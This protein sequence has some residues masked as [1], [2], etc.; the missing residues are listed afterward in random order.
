MEP[1]ITPN[2]QTQPTEAPKASKFTII[3]IV[4]ILISAGFL[5]Y[6]VYKSN[7]E[8]NTTT[9]TTDSAT[10]AEPVPTTN[11]P[12]TTPSTD[13]SAPITPPATVPPASTPSTNA[14]PSGASFTAAQ[15][16]EKNSKSSCWTIIS[17]NVYD[18]TSYVPNHPGGEAEIVK[19]CGKDGTALF[20]KPMEHKEGGASNVLAGF[21]VGTLAQ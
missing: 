1:E 18:I 20:A 14:V 9:G 21:K 7:A 8:S 16:A 5:G 4:L 15:V 2:A 19:V 10:I 13:T 12:G 17:G 3:L 11:T 6:L